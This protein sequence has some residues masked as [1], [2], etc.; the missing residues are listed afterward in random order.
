VTPIRVVR[1][2]PEIVDVAT[3]LPLRRRTYP[4]GS[5]CADGRSTAGPTVEAHRA[6]RALRAAT[7]GHEVGVRSLTYARISGRTD[8]PRQGCGRALPATTPAQQ[9]EPTVVDIVPG[10]VHTHARAGD[11]KWWSRRCTAVRW[12]GRRG[13]QS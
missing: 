3:D 1:D 7:G 9:E 11:E 2:R 13:E 6:G 10:D 12:M 4:T 8:A 5:A